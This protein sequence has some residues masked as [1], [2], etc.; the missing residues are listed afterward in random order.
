MSLCPICRSTVSYAFSAT[1]LRKYNVAFYNCTQCGFLK[2]ETP[3][4][5]EEAYGCAIADADTGL[6][7]RNLCLS[8]IMTTLLFF[9]FDR[10][11]KYLD[12]AGGYGMLTR[13]MRDVGFNYYWDDK[14]CENF[15]ARGFKADLETAFTAITAFEVMEHVV[16]P[17]SFLSESMA[18]AKTKTIFFSTL[19]FEGS[20]P[21]PGSWWYYTHET[22]QHI[23][24]YQ[25]RTLCVLAKKLGLN[26]Y[27]NRS[28]HLLTNKKIN[29]FHYRFLSHPYISFVLSILCN[30]VMPSKT[31]S[32]HLKLT[33]DL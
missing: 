29:S 26:L 7:Q 15:L 8:K 31:F 13:L 4:W 16:D 19:L 25:K 23:S 5:L 22:G 24:F 10:K 18:Q 27:S 33:N 30:S 20:P 1:L 21:E 12:I 2:T 32:D 28:I 14:Y 17:L 3:Y 9:L 6:V 11:G